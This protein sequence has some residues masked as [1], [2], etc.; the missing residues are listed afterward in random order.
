M[1]LNRFNSIAPYYDRLA[2]VVFGNSIRKSQTYYFNRIPENAKV[3]V[4]GGGTGWWLG[5]L[6][7]ENPQCKIW[8][9][10][11]SS[12][13]LSRAQK[14]FLENTI[15]IHGT[16]EDIPPIQFDVVITH[17]FLDMFDDEKMKQLIKTI[18]ASLSISGIWLIA[19]FVNIRFWHRSLLFLMYRFF[20][21]LGVLQLNTL[22]DWD[23]IMLNQNFNCEQETHFYGGFIKSAIYLKIE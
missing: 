18:S 11:A 6:Q 20:R 22:G 8:F 4:I 3:L 1:K 16:E 23:T 17:F 7:K 9:I 14:K 10:E 5:Q 19:D 21:M 2:A 12:E 13:M 15:F